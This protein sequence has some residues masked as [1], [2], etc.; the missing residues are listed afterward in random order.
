MRETATLRSSSAEQ[1]ETLGEALGRCLA[2]GHVVGLLGDLGAG[3]TCLVRGAARGADVDPSVYVSSPT[4]TLV[5]EYAGRLTLYH[6]DLYRLG[7]PDE[8]WEVGLDGYYRSDGACLV[9]WLDRFPEEAPAERL[10]VRLLV[11]GDQ[12]RRLQLEAY[13]AEHV[14]LLRHWTRRI[15]DLP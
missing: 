14:E 15:H 3:K 2:A 9:E 8:L 1:T 11:E 13:G 12:S 7:D 10:D 5:N 4:F 6:I